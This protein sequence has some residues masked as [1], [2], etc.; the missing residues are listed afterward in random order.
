MIYLD[1]PV[2]WSETC[3]FAGIY[4]GFTG[5][6]VEF[7]ACKQSR[8]SFYEQGCQEGCDQRPI[9]KLICVMN[10]HLLVKNKVIYAT[11]S[12]GSKLMCYSFRAR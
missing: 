4:V 9:E 12:S 3:R 10:D 7:T 2:I 8:F 11:I 1:H 5:I 6:Y